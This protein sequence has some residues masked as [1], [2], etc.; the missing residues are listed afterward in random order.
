MITLHIKRLIRDALTEGAT[1]AVKDH[2]RTLKDCGCFDH[3]IHPSYESQ[4]KQEVL[5]LEFVEKIIKSQIRRIE[6]YIDLETNE[7][8]YWN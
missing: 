5:E 6:R 8:D 2:Y 1:F 3:L 7:Y 4:I